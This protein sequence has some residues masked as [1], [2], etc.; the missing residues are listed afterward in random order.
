MKFSKLVQPGLDKGVKH[1]GMMSE[2]PTLIKFSIGNPPPEGFAVE[3]IRAISDRLIAEEPNSLLNYGSAGGR[4]DFRDA[5]RAFMNRR[6]K[7]INDEDIITVTSGGQQG[8]SFAIQAF[9]DPGDVILCEDPT[10]MAALDMFR[11]LGAKPVG[12]KMNDD[13]ID[14]EDLEKKMQMQPKPKLL[15]IIPDFQNPMGVS[16]PE[17]KRKE[18]CRLAYEY[19]VPVLE[20]NP[21]YEL[22]Y[23]GEFIPLLKHYDEHG[24]VGLVSSMSKIVGPGMRCGF[25]AAPGSFGQAIANLKYSADLHTTTWAQRVSCELLTH[26]MEKDLEGLRKLYEHRGH[27]MQE[28]LAEY[29]HPDV[30]FTHPQGGMFIWVTMPEGTDMDAFLKELDDNRV[31]V[32]PGKRFFTDGTYQTPSFRLSYSL[33]TDEEIEKGIRILG[34]LTKKYCK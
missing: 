3:R 17:W 31:V 19:D 6:V 10:F 2:D 5:I 18:V 15:Y 22:R 14:L 16:L 11:N 25:V 13:G 23:D 32:V 9:C 12:V 29:C 7:V 1:T 28:C 21:Y 34:D 27:K 8:I 33:A 24:M 26:D 20:D 30:H 4:D